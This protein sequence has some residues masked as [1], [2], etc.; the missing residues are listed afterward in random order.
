MKMKI[1]FLPKYFSILLIILVNFNAFSQD[2]DFEDETDIIVGA[3]RM[4]RYMPLL[5]GKSVGLVMNQSTMIGDQYLLDTLLQRRIKVKKIFSP[6]H[7]IRGNADAGQYV[8]GGRDKE[9]GLP[10][11]SLYGLN[12]KPSPEQMAG[13]DIMIFDIQDVGV[14]F[15]TYISTMH[16]VMQACME[17][18]IKLIV[19]DRP[20]P[21]GHYVDGPVLDM[22]YRSFVGMHPIPIV[23]G[24]TVGELAKMINEEGWLGDNIYTKARCT[25]EVIPCQNYSHKDSYPLPVN[26]SPNLPN[27]QSI[28]LYPSLCLFEGTDVSIGRGTHFPFQVYGHPEFEKDL[29][30]FTPKSLPGKAKNPKHRDKTCYGYDLRDVE[31]PGFT[32]KYLVEAYQAFP[33]K[34]DF[35]VPYFQKLIGNGEIQKWI[36]EGKSAEAISKSWQLDV[37]KFKELRKKYL[38]YE[39]FE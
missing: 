28:S 24:M 31:N 20:N 7:G 22:A 30:S 35:F 29:F 9:T 33:E 27:E 36:E 8:E 2:W 39:D 38:L 21:N 1:N 18:N 34:G 10:I 15:Y 19:L 26:P 17:N 13:I 23:H 16:Y 12:K 6:E 3:E 5:Y 14:R 32:L 25:L 11:I 37:Q 4:K